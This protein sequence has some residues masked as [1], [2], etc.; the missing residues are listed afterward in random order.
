MIDVVFVS[1]HDFDYHLLDS[2]RWM[3]RIK[4]DCCVRIIS[5][6]GMEKRKLTGE[7]FCWMIW[8][9]SARS[10]NSQELW[11]YF[12]IKTR[13]RYY[14]GWYFVLLF[15]LLL[16]LLRRVNRRSNPSNLVVQTD[17]CFYCSFRP[18]ASTVIR[19]RDIGCFIICF[20]PQW[21]TIPEKVHGL[22]SIHDLFTL[23]TVRVNSCL[24]TIKEGVFR[25]IV[26][27]FCFF[28][29]L[30]FGSY[31]KCRW[32]WTQVRT[33]VPKKKTIRYFCVTG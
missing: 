20:F 28:L 5:L 23:W 17:L 26:I 11:I 2:D 30:W 9:S 16:T 21:Q 4:A 7:C 3:W 31:R 13:W 6:S 18:V 27:T 24:K 33:V 29:D 22:S 32:Q 1:M 12:T 10:R 8:S 14:S 25:K 19:S 15:S